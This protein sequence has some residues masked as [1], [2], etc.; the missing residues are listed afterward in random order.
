M[1]PATSN[2]R[3]PLWREGVPALH[4]ARKGAQD[5]ARD[6]PTLGGPFY[7]QADCIKDAP[8]GAMEG[9]TPSLQRGT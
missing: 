4:R 1:A 7:Q 9:E 2:E 6:Q 3:A 5:S 8:R